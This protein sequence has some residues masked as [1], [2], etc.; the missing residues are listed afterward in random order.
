LAGLL[1]IPAG[2]RYPSAAESPQRQREQTLAALRDVALGLAARDPMLL[3]VEDV[4][5]ID[6]TS[7]ELL[8]LLVEPVSG[9]RILLLVT[10]RAGYRP[11]W[12]GRPHVTSCA[13]TRLGRDEATEMVRH[14]AG[15]NVLPEA[16]LQEIV[17]RTDG[18]PLFIEEVTKAVLESGALDERIDDRARA[19]RPPPRL[20]P[21]TLQDSLMARLDQAG[22]LKEVAQIGSVIGRQFSHA[23]L[24]AVAGLSEVDLE[25]ALDQLV[26]VELA[27]RHGTPPHATYTFKHALVQEAAYESLLFPRRQALHARVLEMLET[28]RPDV[29]SGSPELLAHHAAAAGLH[30]KAVHYR[31]LAGLRASE[32]SANAEAIAHLTA[33]LDLLRTMP[34]SPERRRHE[35]A[36]R[37]TLGPVLIN[38]RGPR[39]PAVAENYARALE[40]CDQLPES[41]LHFAAL[42]GSSRI[43]QNFHTKRDREL[44]LLAVAERLGDPGLRL[45]AHHRLW[46]SLFH[47]G[48]HETCCEH[49]GR[50]L[51]LYAGGDYRAHSSLYGGHDPR[52]CG[53]GE[54]A[55]ALWLLGYPDRSQE[56]IRDALA[57]AHSLGHVGSIAH[58]M[59]IGLMVHRYRRDVDVVRREAEAMMAFG[60]EHGLPVHRAKGTVFLGWV[61][62]ERGELE[63]G[64]AQMRE[65]LEVQ[66]AIG[67]REDFPV[68]YEMLAG[69]LAGAGH[70]KMALDLLAEILDE[71]AESGL[72]YWTPELY[73]VRGE[74]RLAE[75]EDEAQDWFRRGLDF[76]RGQ[77]ARSLELRAAASLARLEQ[78]RGRPHQAYDVLAPLYAWFREGL[79][80]TD[81]VE[82]RKLLDTLRVAAS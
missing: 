73:R 12:A 34:E 1:S 75:S 43:S 64:I 38:A 10:F 22:P 18:V 82:A 20:V 33:G 23:L 63:R 21:P 66:K 16:V 53:L 9:A 54:K 4:H 3:I 40:L 42:W 59:D 50:G 37:V 55:L 25:G 77:R 67:S 76:A 6:P 78:S 62:A 70:G 68:F 8:D 30:E 60:E 47:L 79:D 7:R 39:T 52:V 35:L 26:R 44:S 41:P 31:H 57:W 2:D 19:G 80:T 17:D 58:A 56:A 81:L 69:A 24:A 51:D 74:V 45:Q 29:A 32:R 5:W 48:Q 28:T 15:G 46:A 49:I 36:V 71:T 14:L 72:G 65:G 27:S 13:M 11:A 61:L